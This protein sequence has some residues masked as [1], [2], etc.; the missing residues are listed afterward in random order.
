M[1]NPNT[2]TVCMNSIGST[3]I[4]T[5]P[6][7][8]SM[9][10]VNNS[11]DPSS[12]LHH[13]R[14]NG[15]NSLIPTKTNPSNIKI[16]R[17]KEKDHHR[18]NLLEALNNKSS[19][20]PQFRAGISSKSK[21]LNRE[22]TYSKIVAEK[23]LNQEK[24]LKG[25]GGKTESTKSNKLNAL[26][27]PTAGE[28]DM[29]AKFKQ[30]LLEDTTTSPMTKTRIPTYEINK[31]RIDKQRLIHKNTKVV[32]N[33]VDETILHNRL[34]ISSTPPSSVPSKT[35]L[36]PSTMPSLT[37]SSTVPPMT[38]PSLTKI[39]QNPLQNLQARPT[40]KQ[41]IQKKHSPG[42][43]LSPQVKQKEDLEGTWKDL[44]RLDTKNIDDKLEDNLRLLL[45]EADND[46]EGESSGIVQPESLGK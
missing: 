40:E 6:A 1:A 8:T 15:N 33:R 31:D 29:E 22:K 16:A 41:Q 35:S 14:N 45:E 25:I 11:T 23:R 5:I 19:E 30:R 34:L 28:I 38:I 7:I 43:S 10:N 13:N 17:P 36:T 32:L 3:N 4:G 20:K 27:L 42:R 18:P 2:A 44:M 39:E 12:K 37:K 46:D 26:S 9:Q 24:S 21:D